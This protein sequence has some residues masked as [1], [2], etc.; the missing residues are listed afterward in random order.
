MV[1][2][3]TV[4]LTAALIAVLA[5]AAHPAAARCTTWSC[6]ENTPILSGTFIRGLSTRGEADAARVTLRPQ[7]QPAATTGRCSGAGIRMQVTA[8][9]LTG[10]RRGVV[11]CE[12]AEL[13]GATFAVDVPYKATTMRHEL[14]IAAIDQVSTWEMD[15]AVVVPTYRFEMVARGEVGPTTA[16][17]PLPRLRTPVPLCAER[18]SWMEDWQI[19]D[20]QPRP[21]S[22]AAGFLVYV[23]PD[24]VV[25]MQWRDATDHAL[26]VDGETYDETG[27]AAQH[28]EQWFQIGCAG[29]AIAKMRLLG[30]DPH[31]PRAVADA[32]T[33]TTL[34]MLG[35][36]YG[37]DAPFTRPGTPLKWQRTDGRRYYGGPDPAAVLGP[38]EAGWDAKGATCVSHLRLM[39][40]A[41]VGTGWMVAMVEGYILASIDR[42]Y[43]LQP[44]RAPSGMWITTTVDHIDHG[45]GTGP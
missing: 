33:T 21:L 6:G 28:G 19:G 17:L 23:N 35:A 29:S 40:K 3:T 5:A 11:V 20:M 38:V 9:V 12:G 1:N 25:G 26:L 18:S 34:R 41:V 32:A 44:C 36:R 2:R 30:V 4:T 31:D 15:R 42:R 16:A 8:G 13:V 43:H 14:R 27:G 24:G 39:R 22:P 10:V 7:L 37:G 45:G